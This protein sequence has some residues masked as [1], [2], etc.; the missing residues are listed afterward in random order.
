MESWETRLAEE[1]Q[2]ITELT[3]ERGDFFPTPKG[4]VD[5]IFVRW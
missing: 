4:I 3:E 1:G 5:N 2:L